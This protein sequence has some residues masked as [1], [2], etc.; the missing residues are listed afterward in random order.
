MIWDFVN[1]LFN[2]VAAVFVL[3]NA[4]DVYV[5]KSVAGHTYPSAVFFAVW[6]WFSIPY[7]WMIEQY[8][9]VVPNIT[10][11]IANSILLWLVFK[12]RK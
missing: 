11:A 2:W 4:R 7:F 9:T 6:A 5:Q 1:S 8:W 12:Y 3:L 10:M